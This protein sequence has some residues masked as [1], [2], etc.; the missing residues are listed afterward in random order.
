[1]RA[2]AASRSAGRRELARNQHEAGDDDDEST[3]QPHHTMPACTAYGGLQPRKTE[4]RHSAHAEHR[5]TVQGAR[6]GRGPGRG[7]V[8]RS[9]ESLSLASRAATQEPMMDGWIS[10]PHACRPANHAAI[11]YGVG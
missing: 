11:E 2:E 10:D 7:A 9:N 5:L 8:Q 4:T 3:T 1:M 6:G